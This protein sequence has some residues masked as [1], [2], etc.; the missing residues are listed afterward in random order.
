VR[1]ST[2]DLEIGQDEEDAY[3]EEEAAKYKPLATRKQWKMTLSSDNEEDEKIAGD[4]VGEN[5]FCS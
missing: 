4:E 3:L 5:V 1:R 2:A